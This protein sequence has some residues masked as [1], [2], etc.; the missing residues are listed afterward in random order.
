MEQE[1]RHIVSRDWI[2][3]HCTNNGAWTQAQLAILGVSWP[4][5]AGWID[6]VV[7]KP[8]SD[9]ARRQFEICLESHPQKRWR[10]LEQQVPKAYRQHVTAH[11]Q[12]RP[13]VKKQAQ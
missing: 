1:R 13:R 9:L 4:P 3:L 6:R 2:Y 7:G 12:K 10:K 8:I 11:M 5:E